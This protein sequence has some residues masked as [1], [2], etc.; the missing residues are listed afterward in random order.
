MFSAGGQLG[1]Q[2][3]PRSPA[4]FDNS[5]YSES[6]TCLCSPSSHPFTLLLLLLL[7]L[8]LSYSYSYSESPTCLCSTSLHPVT[9]LELR[10]STVRNAQGP[11][12]HSANSWLFSRT[13]G[14]SCRGQ[15][16]AWTIE[17]WAAGL[18]RVCLSTLSRGWEEY[19]R[20]LQSIAECY[21]VLQSIAYL[22][23]HADEKTSLEMSLHHPAALECTH[24][25]N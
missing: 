4:A 16:R 25:H 2:T 17:F 19:C 21:R 14:A 5:A 9:T 12:K 20:V 11:K 1:N 22:P 3:P 15:N 6:P 8:L 7:L 24:Q 18:A 10:G 23:C 13:V